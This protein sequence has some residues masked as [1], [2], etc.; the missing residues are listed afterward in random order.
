VL[1]GRRGGDAPRLD[2]LARPQ[3]VGAVGDE[4]AVELLAPAAS[5]SQIGQ[6]SR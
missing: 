3:G 6:S 1:Q 5:T 2:R 4:L